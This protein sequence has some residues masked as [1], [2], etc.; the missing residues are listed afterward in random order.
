M[1][2]ALLSLRLFS[3]FFLLVPIPSASGS[4]HK[5]NN[6]AKSQNRSKIIVPVLDRA[7]V[8]ACFLASAPHQDLVISLS[9]SGPRSLYT[10]LSPSL[11]LSLSVPVILLRSR[12]HWHPTVVYSLSSYCYHSHQTSLSFYLPPALSLIYLWNVLRWSGTRTRTR[13]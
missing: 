13:T 2:N 1:Y 11:S 9:E 8:C 3:F 6:V 10:A 5:L 12:A 4:T 7:C